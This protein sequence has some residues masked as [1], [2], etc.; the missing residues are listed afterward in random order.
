MSACRAGIA[1]DFF[2]PLSFGFSFLPPGTSCAPFCLVTFWSNA[3]LSAFL[4]VRKLS[5]RRLCVALSSGVLAFYV[6][7]VLSHLSSA[8]CVY[9]LLPGRA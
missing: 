7:E 8:A 9:R 6:A 4:R 3:T 1:V 5:A 2:L